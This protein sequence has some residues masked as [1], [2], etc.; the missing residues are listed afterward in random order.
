MKRTTCSHTF[1]EFIPEQLEE[2]RVYVSIT[3]A[4]AVHK[5]FCGCGREVVTPISPVHWQLIFDGK[6]ISLD[7]SVGSWAL[8]CQSHYFI[9]RNRVLW[10]RRW[11]KDR[12]ETGRARERAEKELHFDSSTSDPLMRERPSRIEE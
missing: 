10:A 6:T 5:C 9:R 8:P 12:I 2:G 7:P 11:S 4:T 3:Y 1:V